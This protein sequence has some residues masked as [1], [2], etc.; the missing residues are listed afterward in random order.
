MTDR[1]T[2]KRT[3]GVFKRTEDITYKLLR[4]LGRG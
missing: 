1:R 2:N 4:E 3:D